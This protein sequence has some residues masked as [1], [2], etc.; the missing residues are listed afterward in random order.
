MRSTC[1]A[2]VLVVVGLTGACKT[3]DKLNN[4]SETPKSAY[5]GGRGN[6]TTE[7]PTGLFLN[8]TSGT[9]PK[10]YVTTQVCA[11]VFEL[12]TGSTGVGINGLASYGVTDWFEAG[13]LVFDV[14]N[15][16]VSPAPGGVLRGRFLKDDGSWVPEVSAGY[17]GN[18][19]GSGQQKNTL[20]LAASKAIPL[21][22]N[23]VVKSSRIHLGGRESWRTSANDTVGW[24]GAE[25]EFP[26]H[27]FLVGE[28]STKDQSF[29]HIPYAWGLQ[30][31]H[32]VG[33]GLSLGAVQRGFSNGPG[34]FIGIGI[35]FDF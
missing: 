29:P 16:G 14:Y 7:G 32:P 21:P 11:A 1:A 35:G 4:D 27:L 26:L 13:L 30:L 25:I 10:G 24:V 12:P 5:V 17:Y 20:F 9:T 31:R 19:G 34:F 3:L 18:Y 6:V 8:P 15:N 33:I 23:K 28:V 2:L 22:E